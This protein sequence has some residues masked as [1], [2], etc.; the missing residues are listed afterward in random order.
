MPEFKILSDNN[1]LIIYDRDR[2]FMEL[3]LGE[4]IYHWMD[5]VEEGKLQLSFIKAI[6]AIRRAIKGE[7]RCLKDTLK[8]KIN[9]S[10]RILSDKHN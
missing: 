9:V 6:Y 1:V 10:K 3:T 8:G 2:L 4:S 7:Y 5:I